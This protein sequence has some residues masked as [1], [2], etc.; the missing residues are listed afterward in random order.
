ML[1]ESRMQMAAL[2][3]AIQPSS[4]DKYADLLFSL[5]LCLAPAS[6]HTALIYTSGNSCYVFVLFLLSLPLP[7]SLSPLSV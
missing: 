3:D 5:A 4:E 7:L 1:P 2:Y 6:D